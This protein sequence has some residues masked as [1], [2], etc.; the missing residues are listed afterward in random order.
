VAKAYPDEYRWVFAYRPGIAGPLGDG[1][2]EPD[3][4][5]PEGSDAWRYYLESVVPHRVTVSKTFY[6]DLSVLETLCLMARMLFSSNSFTA[7]LATEHGSTSASDAKSSVSKPNPAGG[8][9]RTHRHQLSL[10]VWE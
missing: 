7:Y 9:R 8:H 3:V 6:D 5:L 10:M 2:V 1:Y 4:A